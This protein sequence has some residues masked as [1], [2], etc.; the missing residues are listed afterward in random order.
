MNTHT[1]G[2]G[3]KNEKV[4]LDKLKKTMKKHGYV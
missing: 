4:A 1:K 3:K 2:E